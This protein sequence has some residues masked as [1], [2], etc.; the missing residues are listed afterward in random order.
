MATRKEATLRAYQT[1]NGP[2][3]AGPMWVTYS[4][5]QID[6]LLDVMKQLLI[7]EG[8]EF[9]KEQNDHPE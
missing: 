8:F 4:R 7:L 3:K 6:A 9:R 2:V 1:I 5:S